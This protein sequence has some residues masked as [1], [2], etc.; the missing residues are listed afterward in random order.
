MSP[1]DEAQWE[2]RKRPIDRKK[3]ASGLTLGGDDS[4]LPVTSRSLAGIALAAAFRP[5]A[6]SV[7][8]VE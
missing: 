1:L 2:T 8:H 3:G 5:N 7:S 6:L 4:G